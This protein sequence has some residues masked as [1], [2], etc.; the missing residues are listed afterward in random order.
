MFVLPGKLADGGGLADS[1]HSH[2][3]YHVGIIALAGNFEIVKLIL[4]VRF[5]KHV[6]HFLHKHPAEF[7]T[8]DI[9]VAGDSLFEPLDNLKCG[10]GA[11]IAHDE[12]FLEIVENFVVD[13]AFPRDGMRNLVPHPGLR[14]LKPRIQS[15][16]LL[17]GEKLE[18]ICSF[19]V[20]MH[21]ARWIIHSH[22]S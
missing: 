13:L 6:G 21:Y 15:L 1:V 14:F 20:V 10:V 5:L 12:C 19:L 22:D 11:D 4:I 9:L 17:F 2:H 16:F 3:K 8:S 7:L 18:H